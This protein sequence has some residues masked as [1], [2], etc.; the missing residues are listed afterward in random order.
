MAGRLRIFH[1]AKLGR[2]TPD[3]PCTVYFEEAQ[4]KSLVCFLKKTPT[5]PTE[6]PTLRDAMRK[7][8]TLGGFVGGKSDNPGTETLW[9]GLPRLD[10]ITATFDIIAPWGTARAD[11]S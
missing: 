7:V 5:P 9:R 10:D 3:A 8:A 4:W 2:E 6:P 11:T 1:L